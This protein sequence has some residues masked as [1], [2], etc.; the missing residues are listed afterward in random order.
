MGRH[1][2][3]PENKKALIGASIEQRMIDKI[4]L[5]NCKKIAEEAVIKH[6]KRVS[7]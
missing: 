2:L 7:K 3:P 5:L 6:F 1:T 4:G